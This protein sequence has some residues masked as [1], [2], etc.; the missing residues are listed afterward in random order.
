MQDMK[1]L[2]EKV[3]EMKEQR[4]MLEQQLR[5]LVHKDDITQALVTMK[6]GMDVNVRGVGGRREGMG[7][8]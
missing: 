2:L 8:M 5:D 3:D 1:R 6:E 7:S 4:T